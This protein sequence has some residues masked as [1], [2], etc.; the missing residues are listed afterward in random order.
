MSS[1]FQ[2]GLLVLRGMQPSVASRTILTSFSQR[3]VGSSSCMLSIF[4]FDLLVCFRYCTPLLPVGFVNPWFSLRAE[5][6]GRAAPND[7]DGCMPPVGSPDEE[8]NVF[9][10]SHREGLV[11]IFSR[12]QL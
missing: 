1:S 5:G 2:N 4:S 3:A 7:C 10:G 11:S 9:I 8:L 12:Y 6:C